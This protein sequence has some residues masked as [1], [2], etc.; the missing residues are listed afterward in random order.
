MRG[1]ATV[2]GMAILALSACAS[3]GNEDSLTLTDRAREASSAASEGAGVAARTTREGIGDA[4][5]APLEDLNIRREDIPEELEDIRYVYTGDPALT[6]D[7][8]QAEIRTLDPI[9]GVDYD[10]EAEQRSL[11]ERGGE[12]VGDL[13]LDAVRSATTGFIPFRGVVREAT[14]AARH[15]RRVARA[16]QSGLAR[17]AFLNGYGAAM[18]CPGDASP[19]T[20][21]P[22]PE[23]EVVIE[24][25]DVRDA[26]DNR[27]WRGS[28]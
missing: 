1:K 28:E 9:L 15:A 19:T 24:R 3:D 17:R 18:G 20:L 21:T 4:A 5:Q 11:G 16:Y 13:A 25:R 23:E 10:E 12:A 7:A 22:P 26:G 6:C 14:G 27:R 8:I 2:F